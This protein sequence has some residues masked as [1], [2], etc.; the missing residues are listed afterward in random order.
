V[1]AIDQGA[2][3]IIVQPGAVY[4]PGDRSSL[5]QMMEWFYRGYFP[6][7]PAPELSFQFAYIEDV[8][9]GHILAAERGRIGETYILA[10]PAA[11]LRQLVKLWAGITGRPEPLLYI[12]PVLLKPSAPLMG[13]F[14]RF[15]DLPEQFSEEALRIID[16]QYLA[17]GEKARRELGWQPRSLEEGMRQT[18]A[19]LA[20]TI[21]APDPQEIGRRFQVV[22]IG[23]AS[24]AA[25]L[26]FGLL[27][28]RKN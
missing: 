7:F 5:G 10:G 16:F 6:F 27:R 20:D 12:P 3:V 26:V 14:G 1:P 21:Q 2:P 19:F 13:L 25:M 28:S 9:D 8:V 24:L 18:L 23:A 15:I 11:S 17:S 4:G 22:K